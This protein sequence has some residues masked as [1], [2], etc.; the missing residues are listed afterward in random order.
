MRR[1]VTTS[2]L[3]ILT[4]L[5]VHA[6]ATLDGVNL[7]AYVNGPKI[8]AEDLKGRVVLFEY[9]GVNCPPCLASISHLAA[10]QKA[11]DRDSFVIVA[12]HC[13]GGTVENTKQVWLSKGGGNDISVINSGELAGSNVSGIPH[14][15][16][17]D[18]NGKL[19][20]D[21]SPFQ[22]EESLKK[23]VEASPGHLVAGYTWNKLRK[24]AAA[25]GKRQGVAAAL[26]TARKAID[27]K[28]AGAATEATEL[29]KRIE[30][31]AA[32]STTE[33]S[34]A[35][36]EDPAEA[37]RIALSLSTALKG[38]ALAE[39]F[40]ALVKELKADKAC[41]SAIKGAELLAKV[42][43]QA[44]TYGLAQ[45]PDG[46]LARASNKGKAQEIAQGLKAIATKHAGT[47]AAGQAEE[48]AK[49]WKLTG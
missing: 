23:A 34:K 8:T 14:C 33:A 38:D 37:Y 41:Q 47:K 24:E 36:S 13:Q 19:V 48:L 21:G 9:W 49:S 1:V 40:D 15:F 16:L 32:T 35:R 3:L 26:K 46:W 42:K 11:Y 28:D 27:G 20:F 39:P 29:V 25:V 31:W 45:D 7:G 10:W 44:E 17:F 43:A 5:A 30:A 4:T 12:N 22:V 18:A 6:A 2:L